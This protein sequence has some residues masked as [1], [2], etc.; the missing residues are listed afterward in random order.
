[1][2]VGVPKEIKTREYRVG[3]VPAGVRQLTSAGHTVLVETNAG[4]GSG[5][6]DSEYVRVGA[7]IVATADEVWKRAEMIVKVKEPIAPEYE[8]IQ[9]GQ[10]IYTYFHLAGVDP[11]LTKV[12]LKKKAAAVAYETLQLDDGSLPLLKPMSEVAGKMAIQVG[13]RCLE[14]AMS[15]KGILLGGVPGVRRGRV[16]IIGGGVVG[17]CSAKVAVGMGAEVTI[18]DVNLDRLTYLDDVFLGRVSVLASDSESIAKSVREADLVVGGVLIPGG[19]APKLVSEALIKEMTPGSVVVDVAVDQGGCIETC[20]PTTHDNPTYLVH[21]V[22]HYCV[23]N[24][25]GAVPQTSTYALTNATRPYALKLA[26]LGVVEA[27]KADRALARAIN[28]YAGH[29]TYEAVAKDM[30][31]DYLP[32]ADAFAGKRK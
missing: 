8:R 24:M 13:A 12:L 21:D 31:Y 9:D 11:E 10:I 29:V 7:Q 28:T 17:L 23:A 6:P 4:V 14:K 19:K 15:G 30:G 5:V 2:I 22:V 16:T 3:M 26:N 27:V 20:R 18:L 25:P 32:V 1:M